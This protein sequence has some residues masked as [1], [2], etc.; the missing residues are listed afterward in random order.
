MPRAKPRHTPH[1]THHIDTHAQQTHIAHQHEHPH[2][3]THHSNHNATQ[4]TRRT[5]HAHTTRKHHI[6]HKTRHERAPTGVKFASS[7]YSTRENS[8]SPDTVCDDRLE[9]LSW[10]YAP[11]VHCRSLLVELLVCL[12]L[13][14]SETFACY[15]VSSVI[16][17]WLLLRETVCA[18]GCSTCQSSGSE[19]LD[20]Y[21]CNRTSC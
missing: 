5:F 18:F 14:M 2:T 4:N 6:A 9:A 3:T 11:V 16:L 12:I 1:I 10:F 19:C 17:I 13:L 21:I 20:M 15:V 8:T 7:F